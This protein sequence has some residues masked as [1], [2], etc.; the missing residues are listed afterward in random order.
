[1]PEESPAEFLSMIQQRKTASHPKPRAFQGGNHTYG[2]RKVYTGNEKD[3]YHSCT[4][5]AP[6]FTS[7]C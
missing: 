6:P 5:Y 3:I 2:I 1:M 7:I 4:Q